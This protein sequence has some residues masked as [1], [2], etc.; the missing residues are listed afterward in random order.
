MNIFQKA[1]LSLI[2]SVFFFTAMTN[3][4][5]A[6]EMEGKCKILYKGDEVTESDCK[7]SQE[8]DVVV[9]EG[10]DFKAVVN[11]S[12]DKAVLMTGK[13]VLADGELRSN[14]SDRILFDNYYELDVEL[15]AQEALEGAAENLIE[16]LF[17]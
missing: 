16:Q 4:A 8:D 11:N 7:I 17:K 13:F 10:K 5:M 15:S 9:I 2:P 6:S 14:E 1:K 12:N 3:A